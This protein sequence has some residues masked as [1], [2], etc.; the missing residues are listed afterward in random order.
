MSVYQYPRDEFD[1][2]E[3]RQAPVGVHRAP[4]SKWS[5]I[6]PFLMVAAL[7]AT[8]RVVAIWLLA[9]P[10]GDDVA[11]DLVPV[12]TEPA[13]VEPTEPEV[14]DPGYEDGEEYVPAE[15]EGPEPGSLEALLEAADLSLA[16]RVL[17]DTAPSGEAGRGASALADAGF[18]AATAGNYPGNSGL[19]A[20]SVWYSG[21]N[22]PTAL[23]VAKVLGIPEDRVTEHA[24]QQGPI[25]VVLRGALTLPAAG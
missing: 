13:T 15:P 7:C 4:R 5:R 2:F 25:N 21:D 22:L 23:A 9:R 10:G 18:I 8:V 12:V 14:V 16:V 3:A 1:D 17:N 6:W 19:T 11:D 20:T 24:T